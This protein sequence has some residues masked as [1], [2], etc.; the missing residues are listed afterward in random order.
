MC[1]AGVRSLNASHVLIDQGFAEVYN[2]QG[3]INAAA[4]AGMVRG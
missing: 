1:A 2:V 4:R 3:G